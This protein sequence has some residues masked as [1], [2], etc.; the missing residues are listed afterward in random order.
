MASFGW[1]QGQVYSTSVLPG[2]ER[3]NSISETT[4]LFFDF[5]QTFR[6]SNNYI[7]R[8]LKKKRFQTIDILFRLSVFLESSYL[9]IC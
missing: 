1:D 9:K 4:G 2:E 6:L 5:I 7:Y 3:V 8:Y